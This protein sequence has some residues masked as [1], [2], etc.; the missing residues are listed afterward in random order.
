MN[1]ERKSD[2]SDGSYGEGPIITQNDEWEGIADPEFKAF[3]VKAEESLVT[4]IG[5]Y[6]YVARSLHPLI[7]V[8]YDANYLATASPGNKLVGKL[9]ALRDYG[10]LELIPGEQIDHRIGTLVADKG[11]MTKAASY[12][13]ARQQ[14]EDGSPVE[15]GL[16]KTADLWGEHPNAAFLEKPQKKSGQKEMADNKM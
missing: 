4:A 9:G 10:I 12:I 11:N 8:L 3:M 13:Y 1:P 7:P 2:Q 14:L 16:D 5:K 15:Q 6:Y